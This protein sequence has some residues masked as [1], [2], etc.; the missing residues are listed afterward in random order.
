M[1]LVCCTT[2]IRKQGAPH[3]PFYVSSLWKQIPHDIAGMALSTMGR[4]VVPLINIK[5]IPSNLPILI[6]PGI[7]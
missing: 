1:V 4:M 3:R 6:C 2:A 5:G 7:L